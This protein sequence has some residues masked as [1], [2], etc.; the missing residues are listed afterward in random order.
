MSDLVPLSG[1]GAK[2]PEPS[3]AAPELAEAAEA[4]HGHRVAYCFVLSACRAD[5][6]NWFSSWRA[7]FFKRGMAIHSLA[8]YPQP[9]WAIGAMTMIEGDELALLDGYHLNPYHVEIVQNLATGG[10]V[11]DR[12]I[13]GWH[14]ASVPVRHYR[15]AGGI[16]N[17]VGQSGWLVKGEGML[18]GDGVA[19]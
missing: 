8:L 2:A 13:M 4:Q 6:E 1:L 12:K 5:F 9:D 3:S 19:R 18:R 11:S 16:F 14:Y 17:L 15:L 10:W 7:E